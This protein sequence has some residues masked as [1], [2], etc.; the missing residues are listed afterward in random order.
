MLLLVLL[1][2]GKLKNRK[3]KGGDS[4]E[5]KQKVILIKILFF[6][7]LSILSSSL[8]RTQENIYTFLFFVCFNLNPNWEHTLLSVNI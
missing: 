8:I 6:I 4:K 5:D 3:K 1:D 7:C 2:E